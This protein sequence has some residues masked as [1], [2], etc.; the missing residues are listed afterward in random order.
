MKL[1]YQ[2]TKTEVKVGDVAHTFRGVPVIV[3]SIQ[4][5]HKTVKHGSGVGAVYV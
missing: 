4:A 5:P 1:V 2:S 3:C